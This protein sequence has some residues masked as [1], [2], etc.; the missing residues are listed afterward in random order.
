MS[1]LS[2]CCVNNK[3]FR[4][5]L[6]MALCD[7]SHFIQAFFL[8]LPTTGNI[9]PDIPRKKFPAVNDT[10]K[11]NRL[12]RLRIL[13]KTGRVSTVLISVLWVILL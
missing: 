5:R 6:L 8:P 12:D 2:T 4:H 13:Q 10:R 7:A 9:Y 1:E 11:H 3:Q